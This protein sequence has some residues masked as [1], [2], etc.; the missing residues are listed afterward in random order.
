[1]VLNAGSAVGSRILVQQFAREPVAGKAKTRMQP[2]LDAEAACRLHEALVL[3]T[4]QKL[5][6][7]LPGKVEMWVGGSVEHP[8]F[9]RCESEMGMV[10]RRQQGA[11]LGERMYYALRDGLE[12]ADK[13]V[14]VG[15]DCPQL[16]A[17]YLQQAFAALDNADVVLG[18]ALDGGYVLIGCRNI[19]REVFVGVEWGSAE[20]Y[21]QTIAL[22]AASGL[23]C[24]S[25]AALAD[26]DRPSD[27]PLWQAIQASADVVG[28]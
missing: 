15:S 22:L 20:V 25:L 6:R 27:L 21:A 4:A 16:D 18:P 7:A 3:W 8:L 2:Y 17:N 19:T 24:Q 14:L 12:R 11:D 1:M 10:L 9:G 13:V 26:I 5:T 23:G 28:T